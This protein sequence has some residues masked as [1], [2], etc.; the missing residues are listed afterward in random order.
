MSWDS[1][2]IVFSQDYKSCEAGSQDYKSCEAGVLNWVVGVA[3]L[4]IL[5][6]GGIVL[7]AMH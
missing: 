2:G 5:R 7:N 3:G 1:F 6:S 4:Q